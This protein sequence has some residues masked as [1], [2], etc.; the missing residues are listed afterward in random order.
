MKRKVNCY[1]ICSFSVTIYA[2]VSLNLTTI[3]KNV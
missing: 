1:A 2:E 3:I